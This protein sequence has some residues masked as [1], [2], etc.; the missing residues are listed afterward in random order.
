MAIGKRK[1]A[2]KGKKRASTRVIM[3]GA[4]KHRK[5][6]RRR[7]SGVGAIG[8]TT[9]RKKRKKQGFLGS[10]HGSNLKQIGVMAVGVAVGAGI[11][12]V[13]L[14]PIEKHLTDKW[15]MV[16]NFIA[17]GEVF[18]GGVIA[19]KGKSNFTKSLGV[20]ILAGGVH[21]LMKQAN[22]YKH[23]PGVSGGGDDWHTI[24]IPISG[25]DD[26]QRMVNG[27]LNDGR[28]NIMTDTVAGSNRTHQVA[29][30]SN[31]THLVADTELEDAF[32]F[33][34]PKGAY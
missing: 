6:T 20:G 28:R 19:L 29:D 22:I 5:K 16:G 30:T 33:P 26:M 17:A 4:P 10:T 13:I 8:K 3:V 18:L 7:V 32:S 9:H 31:R 14:R 12:H 21:G 25:A 24:K 27:I 15:P 2:K 11:T 1:P 34:M 23:I